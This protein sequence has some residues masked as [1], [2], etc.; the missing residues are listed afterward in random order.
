VGAL[1]KNKPHLPVEFVVV[2]NRPEKSS[3]FDFR[4][5]VTVVS[6]IL[7][8]GK[9]V[10]LILSPHFHDTIVCKASSQLKPEILTFIMEKSLALI[11]WN[12]CVLHTMWCDLLDIGQR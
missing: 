8:K 6:Y 4:K 5:E 2:K 12:R 3:L 1:K 9:N 11:M 10:I 7:K